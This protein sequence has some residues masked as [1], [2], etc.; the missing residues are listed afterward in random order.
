MKIKIAE[1]IRSFRKEHS[2]TQEQLAEAL[3]VTVGAVYKWEAGLSTPEI[4]LI[5]EL[6]DLF[7]I[8]VDVLLGYEQQDGKVQAVAER[9]EQYRDE[10]NFEQ[11]VAEAEKAL[12]KYPNNFQVVYQSA[13]MYQLK[14]VED[15]EEKS[16]ERSTE[17]FRH[18]VTLLYQ[19]TDE[20]ISEVIILNNIA[21]NYLM[22]GKIEQGLESLKQNNVCGINNSLIG[23]TY[24]T[25]LRQPK[26]AKP[27]LVKALAD[28]IKSLLQT[29]IGLANMYSE[30]DDEMGMDAILWLRGLL[31]SLKISR[32][33]VTF[34][35]KITAVLVAQCAV[36][37]ASMGHFEQA[38]MYIEEAYKLAMQFDASPVYNMQGIKFFEGE[39]VEAVA[40]DDMGKTAMEAVGNVLGE[41]GADAEAYRYV[42]ERWEE[43][44]N[45]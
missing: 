16:L 29:V 3:G 39:E 8:S 41:G 24:A 38:K 43:M 19:N 35:D 7:E 45:E 10:K 20:N 27:Y 17:L 31:D 15:K 12:K 42:Q 11:A 34:T 9:I 37:E 2:L 1:N 6:A 22:L 32:T 23:L 25:L 26:E 36:W 28:N 21:E 44:R 4:K 14:F 5:M 30:L 40:Y 33:E 18:A 13:V